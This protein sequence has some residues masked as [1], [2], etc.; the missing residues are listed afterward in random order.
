MRFA[1][2]ICIFA[3][4]R[5]NKYSALRI[6]IDTEGAIVKKAFYGARFG[7]RERADLFNQLI[8]FRGGVNAKAALA[9]NSA[10][11]HK[12]AAELF[13]ELCRNENPALFIYI[14]LIASEKH[15]FHL[16]FLHFDAL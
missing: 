4:N 14:V 16:R 13:A 10:A 15:D 1:L 11:Y 9:V 5:R 3:Q 8:P 12:A 2:K 6:E 7:A